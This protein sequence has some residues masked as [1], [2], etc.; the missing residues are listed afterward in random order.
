MEKPSSLRTVTVDVSMKTASFLFLLGCTSLHAT[1]PQDQAAR[2]INQVG[3]DLYRAESVTLSGNVLFSP[4]SL[5]NALAMTYAGADGE[6]RQEMQRALHY[7]SDDE[8][9]N[10][11]FAALN[12][13]LGM[14]A[15]HSREAHAAGKFSSSRS[16]TPI[17]IQNANRLFVQADWSLQASFVSRVKKYYSAEPE[18]QNFRENPEASRDAI[19]QWAKQQ[20]HGRIDTV[21]PEGALDKSTRLVLANALYFR[22]SWRNRFTPEATRSR[23]FFIGG[24]DKQAVPTMSVSTMLGYQKSE[25][26]T[27]VTIPYEDPTLQF[28]VIMPDNLA[29]FAKL[30]RSIDSSDLSE[31]G[32]LKPREILLYMPRFKLAP[33]VM[34][35]KE[36]LMK[37]GLKTAFDQPKG[38]ANFA[39]IAPRKPE[40]YLGLSAVFQKTWLSLDEEGTEAA[41][42]T[43]AEM[44]ALAAMVK[45]ISPPEVHIDRP[46]LFAVQHVE[47]GACLF[48]GRVMDP[49]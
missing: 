13:G 2:A 37:L 48:F 23:D 25:G 29:S 3:L 40:D 21:I 31:W 11:G 42:V 22:A 20:T 32:H 5:Q 44:V 18:S 36:V 33:E 1:T 49:R 15:K 4:Y 16:S 10:L 38:S 8:G 27:V 43:A 24:V 34:A 39:R 35:L 14:I 17:E 45:K 26:L 28:V 46:F 6:T 12:E 41:S 7:G 19:N 9:T 47:S 30:E